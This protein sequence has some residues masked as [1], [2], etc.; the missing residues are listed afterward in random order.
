[1]KLFDFRF[2]EVCAR[3]CVS[4]CLRTC[5]LALPLAHGGT[6]LPVIFSIG[7]FLG[8]GVSSTRAGVTLLL[9]LFCCCSSFLFSRLIFAHKHGVEPP[10]EHGRFSS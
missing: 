3:Q 1:M 6:S 4:Q 8:L 10:R 7:W 9:A 5:C 2:V